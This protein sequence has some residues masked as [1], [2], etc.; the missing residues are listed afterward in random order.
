MS[1]AKLTDYQQ[2]ALET[3]GVLGWFRPDMCPDWRMRDRRFTGMFVKRAEFTAEQL[4]EK[5]YFERR[6]DGVY[7]SSFFEYRVK[8]PTAPEG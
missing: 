2:A 1:V 7:P 4:Y 3:A 8:Q 5:G 6:L